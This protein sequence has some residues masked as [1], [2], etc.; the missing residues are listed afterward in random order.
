MNFYI[1][2]KNQFEITIPSYDQEDYL[3][4]LNLDD[5]NICEKILRK[6]DS[7]FELLRYLIHE[8]HIINLLKIFNQFDVE[9]VINKYD[10]MYAYSNTDVN[11]EKI[12]HAIKLLSDAKEVLSC[13]F[14]NGRQKYNATSIVEV[15]NKIIEEKKKLKLKKDLMKRRRNDFQIRRD[16]LFL[17][18][19]EKNKIE[20]NKCLS[21]ENITIDHII[22][23]SK[24]GSDELEN[25]QL[26]CRSCNSSKGDR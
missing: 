3:I 7:I 4:A 12:D 17:L 22:P 20:C 9:S 18:L 2:F 19:I 16:R 13:H 11:C 24:G 1:N 25:L 10:G 15:A 14:I 21:I 23:L 26:L 6:D 8:K 5:E